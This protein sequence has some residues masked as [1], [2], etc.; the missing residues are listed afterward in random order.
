MFLS[1]YLSIL[2]FFTSLLFLGSVLFFIPYLLAQKIDDK[3]KLSSYE[4]GFNPFS[5]SRNEFEV[6]FY[7]VA[8]LFLI[9]DLEIT[10][11]FPFLMSLDKM[12]SDGIFFMYFFISLLTVGFYYEWKKGALD[13]S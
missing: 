11:L 12:Q 13:W 5:D 6:K 1:N 4:C 7:L 9:F 2:I 10:F 3:E 8:I